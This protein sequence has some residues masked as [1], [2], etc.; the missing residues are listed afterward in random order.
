LPAALRSAPD[1]QSTTA[2]SVAKM[3]PVSAYGDTASACATASVNA[4]SA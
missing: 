1:A 2:R 4:S 3:E